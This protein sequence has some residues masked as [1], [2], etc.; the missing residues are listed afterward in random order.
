VPCGLLARGRARL[1]R[2]ATLVVLAGIVGVLVASTA[3]ASR[4]SAPI[5][6]PPQHSY[7]S[8]GDSF[9]FGL[10]VDRLFELL[11]AGTY[12]PAAFNTGYTDDLAAR[13]LLIRPDQIVENLSCPTESTDTMIMGGC[14]FTHDFGLDIH[15]DYDGSQLDAALA[16][17]RAHPHQVSPITLAIG[18]NDVRS[19]LDRC[20]L[21]NSCI[22]RSGIT[23]HLRR[24][25]GRI[26]GALR[27][28]APETEIIVLAMYNPYKIMNPTSDDIWKRDF[29]DVEADVA[30][31][32][33]ARFA[34]AFAA[35]H[36]T[37]QLC[38]LT[39][40]CTSGDSHPNDAGYLTIAN[41]IFAV[42][43]Y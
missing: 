30:S 27:A 23:Q 17:L 19:V 43:G 38:Q 5:F 31:R 40:L 6:D 22:G 16:F 36:T 39:F 13:L 14:L 1:P 2:G 3:T 4:S 10:Q 25:L 7:L 18:A 33:Q 21:E 24:N 34:N 35:I 42:S 32:Y 15:V 37:D 8:L 28:A 41:L 20:G 11:D 12:T 26:L 9:G 29:V